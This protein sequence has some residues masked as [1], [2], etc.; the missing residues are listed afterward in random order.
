MQKRHSVLCGT[1]LYLFLPPVSRRVRPSTPASQGQEA[2]RP[3]SSGQS[4]GKCF[5]SVR[6][7]AEPVPGGV[8]WGPGQGRPCCLHLKRQP[9]SCHRR[10]TEQQLRCG[11]A[12]RWEQGCPDPL[13]LP[14]LRLATLNGQ[15]ARSARPPLCTAG[16]GPSRPCASLQ[17]RLA[18]RGSV[19]GGSASWAPCLRRPLLHWPRSASWPVI[20][21][22]PCVLLDETRGCPAPP[23]VGT[24]LGLS[25]GECLQGHLAACLRLDSQIRFLHWSPRP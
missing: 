14:A 13:P 4:P 10:T 18:F 1:G 6:P 7:S 21:Y 20:V 11:V 12:C 5:A 24:S 25:P 16:R 2:A 23:V 9:A 19:W 8:L 3:C 22:K 17:D 15:P